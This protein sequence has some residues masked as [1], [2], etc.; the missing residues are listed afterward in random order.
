V[1]LK[2]YKKVQKKLLKNFDTKKVEK[3]DISD[4]KE[5][6]KTVTIFSSKKVKSA[7]KEKFRDGF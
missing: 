1:T 2:R 5:N 6:K 7:K 4:K 3:S